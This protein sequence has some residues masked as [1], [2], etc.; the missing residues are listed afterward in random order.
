MLGM[1]GSWWVEGVGEDSSGLD[2]DAA[3]EDL[4]LAGQPV[5]AWREVVLEHLIFQYGRWARCS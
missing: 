3:A 4:R 5:T 1:L 2:D